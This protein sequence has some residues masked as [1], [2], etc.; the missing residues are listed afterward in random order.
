MSQAPSLRPQSATT[1]WSLVLDLQGQDPKAAQASLLTL[2]LR[3]WYPVYAFIR[4]SGHDPER[5]HDLT[6]GFFQR[7]LR[8]EGS[9]ITAR[10]YVRFR[11]FLLAELHRF[12]ANGQGALSSD[13]DTLQVPDRTEMEARL[14]AET[15]ADQSPEELLR[16]SFA[17]EML[18]YAHKQLRRE[19]QEAGRLAMFEALERYL[20]AEPQPGDYESS[21]QHLGLRPLFVAMAVQRLRQRFRE[22][23][24]QELSE[25]L[26][27]P[28][29]LE[30]ERQE[31]MHALTGARP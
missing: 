30:A 3:Y 18:G 25:T 13:D 12:L 29:E 8:A 10:R 6:R 15:G 22:L 24:D 2:C 26:A 7:L 5:A 20:G 27:G 9:T 23:V 16:R 1:H 4:R 21:A 14:C 28:V 31:L 19:A 17:L 11:Q